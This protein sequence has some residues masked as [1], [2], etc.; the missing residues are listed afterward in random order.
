LYHRVP[1]VFEDADRVLE[2]LFGVLVLRGAII[3][4]LFREVFDPRSFVPKADTVSVGWISVLR[5]GIIP[6]Q[7]GADQ[8]VSIASTSVDRFAAQDARPALVHEQRS[9]VSPPDL[10]MVSFDPEGR[11]DYPA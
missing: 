11:E 3:A 1:Q 5:E 7:L 8:N 10:S 4:V 6:A 9:L 2:P